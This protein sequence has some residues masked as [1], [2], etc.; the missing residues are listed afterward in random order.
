M[1]TYD[2]IQLAIITH[3]QVGHIIIPF[4][5][6][7]NIDYSAKVFYSAN[8]ILLR[9]KSNYLG[10]IRDAI[11]YPVFIVFGEC[12]DPCNDVFSGSP[13]KSRKAFLGKDQLVQFLL[14]LYQPLPPIH[15]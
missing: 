11:N 5:F 6:T 4:G 10:A 2:I 14:I 13:W 15:I 12:S 7:G 8:A 1:T 9:V 3:I